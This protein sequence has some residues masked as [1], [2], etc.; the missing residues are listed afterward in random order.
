MAL[1]LC[2]ALHYFDPFLPL[3]CAPRPQPWRN[4][5]KGRDQILLS[6]I[7]DRLP[8]REEEQEGKQLCYE[9]M[10]VM[11]TMRMTTATSSCLLATASDVAAVSVFYLA[12]GVS[13][14]LLV[15]P[16]RGYS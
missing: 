7:T 5:R 15:Y 8:G 16:F 10:T 1:L 2:A 13:K 14:Q 6:G 11:K 12:F 9:L 3:D 4:P